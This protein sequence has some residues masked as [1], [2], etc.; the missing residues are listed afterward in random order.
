MNEKSLSKKIIGIGLSSL[1]SL[2]KLNLTY[3]DNINDSGLSYL[4]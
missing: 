4:S 3:C 2:K 1:I